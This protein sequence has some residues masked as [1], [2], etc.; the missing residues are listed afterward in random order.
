MKLKRY[1]RAYCYTCTLHNF[2]KM[3]MP[4]DEFVQ[5]MITRML[6]RNTMPRVDDDD[7]KSSHVVNMSSKSA[8]RIATIRERSTLP[9]WVY[10][11][12]QH[13]C[14]CSK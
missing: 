5:R 4:N 6:N 13:K 11:S 1:A 9:M 10:R 7:D 3:V 2:M 12:G 8:Q 14:N